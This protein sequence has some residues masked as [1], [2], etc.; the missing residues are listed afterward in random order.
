MSAF[1]SSVV[2]ITVFAVTTRAIGF[3]FRIF[4]SRTLGAEMLGVYQI[5]MSFFMVFLT[6]VSSGL[7]LAI[8]KRVATK[9]SGGIVTAG[10]VISLVTGIIMCLLV[11]AFRNVIATFFT[12]ERCI[13]ILIALIP[14]VIIEGFYG[15]TRAVWLGE[16]RYFLLGA[17]ELLDQFLRIVVFAVMLTFAFVFTDMAEIAA[18]SYTVAFAIAG[19]IVV[20]IYIKTRTK[21]SP[22]EPQYMPLLRSAAPITGVRLV[23]SLTM[24]IIAVLIPLRLIAS[25]WSSAMAVSSFGILMGMAFPL[26]TIPQTIVSALSTALV[27]ELSSSYS[28]KQEEKTSGQVSNSLKFTLFINFLFLCMFIAAGQGI[29]QFL[30]GNTTS[31]IYLSQYCWV[32]IPMSLSQI[33]NA[34]LNSLGAESRAMKSYFIGAIALFAAIWFLPQYIGISALVIGM[35]VCMSIATLLNLVIIGK[36]TGKKV[37]MGVFSQILTFLIFTIPSVLVGYFTYG[38]CLNFIGLFFSIS[39]ASAAAMAVF[40]LLSHTFGMVKLS[41][42]RVKPT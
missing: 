24:P 26:I 29:G 1:A 13:S 14:S 6:V 11:F 42:F 18:I 2:L 5:A 7:P 21:S 31:G 17:T 41:A 19:A 28:N 20:I 25:G 36:M 30:F 27:P 39:F 38:I 8:S 33:T 23:S 40:V 22:K 35:G 32:M 34:I 15:V 12:D 3:L 10:L 37:I 9:K 4:L 16:K